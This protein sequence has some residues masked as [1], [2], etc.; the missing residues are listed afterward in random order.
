M[1]S[2]VVDLLRP[3]KGRELLLEGHE[4][5]LQVGRVQEADATAPRGAQHSMLTVMSAEFH[6]G[7][8]CARDSALHCSLDCTSDTTDIRNDTVLL[9]SSRSSM[10]QLQHR[11]LQVKCRA[12]YTLKPSKSGLKLSNIR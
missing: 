12:K 11:S 10:F 3:S 2:I 4:R 6:S 1:E 5:T 8:Y 7:S 9:S